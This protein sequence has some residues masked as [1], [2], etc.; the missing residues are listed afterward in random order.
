M[1]PLSETFRV[2]KVFVYEAKKWVIFNRTVCNSSTEVAFVIYMSR[3]AFYKFSFDF[4]NHLPENDLTPA[5]W[6]IHG[7]AMFR[8]LFCESFG[9]AT[10]FLCIPCD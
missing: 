4:V 7:S 5:A 8:A 1:L 6:C 2:E 10:L 3:L 9:C